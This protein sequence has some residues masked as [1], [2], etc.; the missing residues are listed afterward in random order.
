MSKYQK[1]ENKIIYEKEIR[2]KI[3]KLPEN[4]RK[5]VLDYIEF[6]LKKYKSREIK[7]KKF[8]FGWE[9]GLSEIR[10]KFT[11]VELQHKGSEWR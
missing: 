4:L 11:C 5:E 1:D 10:E 7:T 6:L 9:G 3:R 8:K 2:L